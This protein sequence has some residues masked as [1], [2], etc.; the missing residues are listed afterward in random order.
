MEHFTLFKTK[1][2]SYIGSPKEF[3]CCWQEG[4]WVCTF[5]REN[6]PILSDDEQSMLI[7]YN[8]IWFYSNGSIHYM[9]FIFIIFAIYANYKLFVIKND[10][11]QRCP[12]HQ[13]EINQSTN[14]LIYQSLQTVV[15]VI[16]CD[17]QPCKN[18]AKCHQ[19][20]HCECLPGWTGLLC[21]IPGS[22]SVR[23]QETWEGRGGVDMWDT[24]Y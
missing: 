4:P 21:E 16:D 20:S 23:L 7:I 18:N 11:T 22:I 24:W 9:H 8:S 12:S 19:G 3:F 15:A 5:T 6:S 2:S 10:F 13:Q 14:Q 1:I 17:I